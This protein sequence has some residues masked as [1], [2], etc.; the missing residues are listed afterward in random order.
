MSNDT[1]PPLKPL[2]HIG[3]YKSASSWLQKHFFQNDYGYQQILTPYTTQL[4]LLDQPSLCFDKNKVLSFLDREFA[5]IQETPYT[6]VISSENLSGNL[7]CGGYNAKDNADRLS[8]TFSNA[9]ILL[10]T[11]EQKKLIRS[12]YKTM[13]LWGSP[14][15]IKRLLNSPDP[16]S[17]PQFNLDF[18][19]FDQI[20]SYYRLLFGTDNVLVLPYELF[21]EDPADFLNKI[22]AFNGQENLDK[23]ALEKLP[24]NTIV[25]KNQSLAWPKLQQVINRLFLSNAFNYNGLFETHQDKTWKRIKRHKAYGTTPFDDHLER[26]FAH[27]VKNQTSGEFKD[28][29]QK[30]QQFC[31]V[32]LKRY[33]YEM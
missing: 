19:R 27:Y 12:M 4:E 30:L 2:I 22:R 14:L 8:Q 21:K 17:A 32:D 6:S 25:N 24:V 15:S 33:G 5:N 26:R 9:K 18:L 31:E 7:M 10:V 23:G 29:N 1:P 28:S 20:V 11:R 3:F 16:R 13:I